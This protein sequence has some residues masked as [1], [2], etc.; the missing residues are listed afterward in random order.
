MS[1]TSRRQANAENS[2]TVVQVGANTIFKSAG[3]VNLLPLVRTA[4][5][6]SHQILV[7]G[8]ML[9]S[10]HILR[11]LS[12]N[13]PLPPLSTGTK[14][15][16]WQ[17]MMDNC[18]AAVS[19]AVGPCCQQF[20]AAKQP[21]L[22]TTYAQ[23]QQSLPAGHVK[24]TRPTWLKHV[25]K[26]NSAMAQINACNHVS[27]NFRSRTR[28]WIKFRLLQNQ[29]F[30]NLAK[31][32]LN[33]WSSLVLWAG[34]VTDKTATDL[35]PR[36]S[37]LQMPPVAVM[38]FVEALVASL[39]ADV[40]PLPVTDDS[41][42]RQAELYLPWL[43]QM[44]TEYEAAAAAGLEHPRMYTILP[45]ISNNL[46]F[47]TISSSAL[48]R[49]LHQA[50]VPNLPTFST[51][52][53]N[54]EARFTQDD[55]K[56]W[57]QCTGAPAFCDSIKKKFAHRVSTDGYSASVIT[58]RPLRQPVPAAPSRPPKRKR[59]TSD[60]ADCVDPNKQ[61]VRGVDAEAIR[62]V[63]S[64]TNPQQEGYL[65]ALDPGRRSIFTAVVHDPNP[66]VDSQ[67]HLQD[68]QPHSLDKYFSLSWS[69]KRWHEVSGSN[70]SKAKSKH[71]LQEAPAVQAALLSTPSPKTAST[72]AFGQHIQ[73]R[74]QHADAVLSHFLRPRHCKLRRKRKMRYQK[75]LQEVC[76]TISQG[77]RNTIVGYGDARFH[78]SSKGLAPT[79]TTALR[80]H[81]G[82]TCRVCDVDEFRT[83]MLCCACHRPMV[84]MP[85]QP[86]L[87]PGELLA[88]QQ[89]IFA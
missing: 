58:R 86:M 5:T 15:S 46:S 43:Y 6:T 45:Q 41:L 52:G 37:S 63:A 16:K 60:A 49:L 10:L 59:G 75:A 79:P 70:E 48:H 54:G 28:T 84:G 71:W 89:L 3:C 73:H 23:Y 36:F 67:Q 76:S 22:A 80:R 56:W 83:S 12:T 88:P 2:T 78:S 31:K 20:S 32:R 68:P 9:A 53:D 13:Q 27:V 65:V 50:E 29:H 19:Q 44:L 11:L 7:E 1:R 38:N 4:V 25:M 82:T 55:D 51:K 35:L 85:L 40:G 69:N 87:S 74:L 61:W 39:K 18:Y 17:T 42:K 57:R 30:A 33:S 81:L 62:Q 21:E 34:T 72:Q 24:P 26:E 14:E 77:N 47:I 64:S 66:N 8:H